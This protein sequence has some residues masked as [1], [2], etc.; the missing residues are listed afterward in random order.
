MWYQRGCRDSCSRWKHL[1][2]KRGH[3]CTRLERRVAEHITEETVHKRIPANCLCHGIFFTLKKL[4]AAPS[5]RNSVGIKEEGHRR[6]VTNCSPRVV[7]TLT[8][9]ASTSE[10]KRQE[11]HERVESTWYMAREV[12]AS[13]SYSRLHHI[14]M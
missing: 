4:E 1:Q 14:M 13:R 12:R 2:W 5:D 3:P 10:R 8:S 9:P 6:Q 11:G 7:Y